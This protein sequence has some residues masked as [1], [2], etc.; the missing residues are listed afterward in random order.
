MPKESRV[1]PG[2]AR[3]RGAIERTTG[4]PAQPT[5]AGSGPGAIGDEG[6][7][8]IESG[9]KALV[10][11]FFGKERGDQMAF[12]A[13]YGKKYDYRGVLEPTEAVVQCERAGVTMPAD[14]YLCGLP[15]PSQDELQARGGIKHELYPECEH[16]LPVTEARWYLMLFMTTMKPTTAWEQ[17]AVRL[18]YALAHRVCNQAKSNFSF[19]R[20]DGTGNLVVSETG[21]LTILSNIR[22][23]ALDDLYK[24]RKHQ[25][26][27][28]VEYTK[29]DI[30]MLK[31]IAGSI[32]ERKQTI[33]D[34]NIVP[35]LDH[36]SKVPAAEAP[37]MVLL[38][39]TA[40]V[41]DPA[42]LATRVEAV[43]GAWDGPTPAQEQALFESIMKKAYERYPQFEP[44][45]LRAMLTANPVLSANPPE[46][47][48]D[49]Y[50]EAAV[51]QA[52]A[53]LKRY[54]TQIPNTKTSAGD[55]ETESEPA[56]D[57]IVHVVFYGVYL[58]LLTRLRND[59][60]IETS[61]ATQNAFCKLYDQVMAFHDDP[62]VS[63][64]LKRVFGKKKPEISDDEKGFCKRLREDEERAG[65][66]QKR[67]EAKSQADAK[68]EVEVERVSAEEA[69]NFYFDGFAD[70][71]TRK[72]FTG[73]FATMLEAQARESYIQHYDPDDPQSALGIVVRDVGGAVELALLGSEG[74]SDAVNA[75]VETVMGVLSKEEYAD[76]AT[77]A[78][79]QAIAAEVDAGKNPRP[80]GAGAGSSGGNRPTH[81][82][83]LYS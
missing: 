35:I 71:L 5:G 61:G 54:F 29:E 42:A 16:I 41:V 6:E 80:A 31:K 59:P 58:E 18:E 68:E 76:E 9:S 72:G 8:G 3:L 1:P 37:S 4:V 83:A 19:V 78:E 28:G 2:R 63:A 57:S 17:E 53:I 56:G 12:A 38:A 40:G 33:L 44:N 66:A 45:S 23:R 60:I 81:R 47:G 36:A 55:D 27:A 22:D 49:P 20:D 25:L 26:P 32:L 67:E 7:E 64:V 74:F 73:E 11:R 30:D 39:R 46:K 34:N 13:G 77:M 14:C 15:I 70:A 65:R 52:R 75:F 62:R 51:N 21:C 50:Y 48:W 79:V 10:H 24:Q 69:A 82:R 43:L